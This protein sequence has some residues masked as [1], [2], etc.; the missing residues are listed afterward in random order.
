MPSRTSTICRALRLDHVTQP[1]DLHPCGLQPGDG[2]LDGLVLATQLADDPAVLLLDVRPPDVR[3]DVE[4][5]HDAGDERL[6]DEVL[7]KRELDPDAG[8]DPPSPL[9]QR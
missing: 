9:V 4:L 2:A 6:L 7:G 1:V 8:H 5:A 3:H